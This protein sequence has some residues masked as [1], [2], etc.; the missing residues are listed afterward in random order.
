MWYNTGSDRNINLG[1]AIPIMVFVHRQYVWTVKGNIDVGRECIIHGFDAIAIPPNP[2]FCGT[3]YIIVTD[4]NIL[5]QCKINYSIKRI[6][7]KFD[8]RNL[9]IFLA[10]HNKYIIKHFVWEITQKNSIIFSLTISLHFDRYNLH[11]LDE[12]FSS[13]LSVISLDRFI[14]YQ[15][16]FKSL[17]EVESPSSRYKQ[18]DGN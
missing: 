12:S 1:E 6:P 13:N 3:P 10:C 15:L 14:L 7:P 16:P 8:I 9:L 4:Y 5:L 2:H 11:I 17:L 18:I